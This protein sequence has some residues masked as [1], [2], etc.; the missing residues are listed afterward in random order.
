M[1]AKGLMLHAIIG[2][3]VCNG[4]RKGW[5]R[6]WVVG[7]GDMEGGEGRGVGRSSAFDEG[8]NPINLTNYCLA[9]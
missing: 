9:Y 3:R 2:K 5:E 8:D 1:P 7:G 4:K 6:F